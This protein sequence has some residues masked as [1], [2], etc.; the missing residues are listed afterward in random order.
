MQSRNRLLW[1]SLFLLTL[2]M[3]SPTRAQDA[4][5]RDNPPFIPQFGVYE[6][7]DSFGIDSPTDVHYTQGLRLELLL[8]RAKPWTR[9]N[10]EYFSSGEVNRDTGGP[11]LI[12]RWFYRRE[13][14]PLTFSNGVALGQNMYTP[15]DIKTTTFNPDDRPYAAWLYGGLITTVTGPEDDWHDIWELDLGVIGP[16]ALGDEVQSGFHDLIGSPNPTWVN[17]IP[18]E[19]AFLATWSRRWLYPF[20]LAQNP[21]PSWRA[22]IAPLVQVRLG[23][24]F[25][26]LALGTTFM[27]GWNTPRDF[28]A[29]RVNASRLP[30]IGDRGRRSSPGARIPPATPP[31]G[32][33]WSCY[34]F[35]GAEGRAV[36]YNVFLDGTLFRES[37]SV[38]RN[39]L[40][41]DFI[42]GMTIR[43]RGLSVSLA[44]VWRSPEMEAETRYHNFGAFQMVLTCQF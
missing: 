6:E 19:F 42:A 13:S 2:G 5:R 27:V 26:D 31:G 10:G 18:D 14:N 34:A 1:L 3:M 15:Q 38:D 7:N 28:R 36:G 37:H 9:A 32:G 17:Q 16:S 44:Q 20:L 22:F 29:G 40:V 25:T 12:P 39:D 33:D 23:N 24:V 35:L 41:A 8:R 4:P 30:P 43:F 21:E 11:I